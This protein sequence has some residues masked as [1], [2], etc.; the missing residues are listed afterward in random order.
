LPIDRGEIADALREVVASLVVADEYGRDI[1]DVN[2]ALAWCRAEAE[3]A[4]LRLGRLIE[5][6]EGP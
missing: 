2:E 3:V 6:I 5:R 4:R 1:P